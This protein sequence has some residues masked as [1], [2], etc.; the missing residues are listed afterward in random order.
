MIAVRSGS[1]RGTA[2]GTVSAPV[3]EVGTLYTYSAA[4]TWELDAAASD[5][6]TGRDVLRP[7]G[8]V[9]VTP[10]WRCISQLKPDTI[11]ITSSMGELKID[12]VAGTWTGSGDARPSVAGF[13]YYNT[14]GR[15]STFLEISEVPILGDDLGI[16][17]PL[18]VQGRF[19]APAI[20]GLRRFD[21]TFSYAEE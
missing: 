14:C 17:A 16:A 7:R 4:V 13:A 9:I 20:N 6:V 1:L 19:Q 18:P 12:R 2:T 10:V 5:P 21:V 11:T 15:A 8:T 3:A